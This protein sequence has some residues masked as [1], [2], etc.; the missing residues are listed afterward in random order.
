MC[1]RRGGKICQPEVG[2]WNSD[3]NSCR[4]NAVRLPVTR[5]SLSK[6]GLVAWGMFYACKRSLYPRDAMDGLK[7]DPIVPPFLGRKTCGKLLT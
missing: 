3:S 7:F 2:C 1:G 5:V 6:K 4:C